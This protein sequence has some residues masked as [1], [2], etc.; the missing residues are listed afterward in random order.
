MFVQKM[1]ISLEIN[2][3]YVNK[4][5]EGSKIYPNNK[6]KN[7]NARISSFANEKCPVKAIFSNKRKL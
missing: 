3:D 7:Y 5:K 1:M 6:V 4:A 2:E